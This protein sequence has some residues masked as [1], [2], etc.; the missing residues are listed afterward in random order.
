MRR[1][2]YLLGPEGFS[3]DVL[4]TRA[5][6]VI[7]SACRRWAIAESGAR[8]Y[9]GQNRLIVFCRPNLFSRN[10]FFLRGVE[11]PHGLSD[12]NIRCLSEGR[13]SQ[14]ADWELEL[15]AEGYASEERLREVVRWEVWDEQG[16]WSE[17][18]AQNSG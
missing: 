10:S 4:C 3:V 9:H 14:V 15:W 6:Y 12:E 1:A 16:V 8:G 7:V 5:L 18:V 11:T 17:S 2:P 13:D